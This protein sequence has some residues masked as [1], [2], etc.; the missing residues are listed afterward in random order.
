MKLAEE[1]A[2]AIPEGVRDPRVAISPD[3]I[4]L[5]FRTRQGGVETVV[6]VD[7]EV[8]ITET[9]AI[10]VRLKSVQAGALPLPVMQVADELADG[11]RGLSLPVRWT[12][13]DGQ[14]VAIIDVDQ[15]RGD[16][17]P[18]VQI[19]SIELGDGELYVA[20]R[21]EDDLPTEPAGDDP[22]AG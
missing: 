3:A 15:G 17:H 11:C 8:F 21:T 4:T 16:G 22:G 19:N 2:D 9:G 5:G 1:F 20:G 14:P 12:Q 13:Q 6:S 18:R 10:A 7:A